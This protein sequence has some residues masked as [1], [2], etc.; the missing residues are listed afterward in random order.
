VADLCLGKTASA[1]SCVVGATLQYTL[2]LENRGPATA[3]ETCV[4]DSLP[5]GLQFLSATA[6]RGSVSE[7]AGTVVAELGAMELC[8]TAAVTIRA[9]ATE[10]GEIVNRA[11]AAALEPDPDPANNEA[12]ATVRASAP[13]PDLTSSLEATQS[14][15]G[16]APRQRAQ[17]RGV[18]IVRNIGPLGAGTSR[19][20]VYLS[21]G[22]NLVP[23]D[24]TVI[25][26]QSVRQ[27]AAAGD[28]RGRDS[29]TCRFTAN[30]PAGQTATGKYLIA[31][32]DADGA[33]AELRED[34]NHTVLGPIR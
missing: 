30:L 15:R 21:G 17:I 8:T 4:V 10:A 7:S 22:P 29:Q 5:A 19:L 28:S 31:V 9:R 14:F 27:L 6:T 26:Q 23:P 34:N 3:T 20:R 13:L 24:A 11:S 33:V 25:Y 1:E 16:K 12:S 2:L 32:V 18:C